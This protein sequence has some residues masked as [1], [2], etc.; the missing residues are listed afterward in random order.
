MRARSL[1]VVCARITYKIIWPSAV[2]YDD[3]IQ[4]AENTLC[5]REKNRMVER[6]RKRE[7]DSANTFQ[8]RPENEQI[9]DKNVRRK[10]IDE[11]R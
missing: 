2:F 10:K 8:T 5:E 3:E 7:R 6:K 4:I 1:C 11:E 9:T